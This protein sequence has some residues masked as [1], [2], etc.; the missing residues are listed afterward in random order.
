MKNIF[1]IKKAKAELE[2]EISAK[3]ES[4]EKQTA[5]TVAAVEYE[6]QEIAQGV[7]VFVVNHKVKLIVEV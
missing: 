3:I 5:T 4:F 2:K 7:D 6:K 1:D